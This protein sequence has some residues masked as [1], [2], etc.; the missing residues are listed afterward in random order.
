[1]ARRRAPE[2][3]GLAKGET[4]T[5]GAKF[6]FVWI[7][8]LL[9]GLSVIAAGV[10]LFLSARWVPA[11]NPSFL[12]SF[13]PAPLISDIQR[14][15]DLINNGDTETWTHVNEF[16]DRLAGLERGWQDQPESLDQLRGLITKLDEKIE[17][18]LAAVAA[19]P[20]SPLSPD[21]THTG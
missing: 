21:L 6:P 18:H 14:R 4:T 3:A 19:N 12:P 10:S 1:M 20:T 9:L 2:P 5:P 15:L 16:R 11:V 7:F 8:L 13:D 17:Q